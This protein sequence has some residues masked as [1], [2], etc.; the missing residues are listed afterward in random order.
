MVRN[1]LAFTLRAI[2]VSLALPSLVMAEEPRPPAADRPLPAA[3]EARARA[4]ILHEALHATLQIVHHTYFSED[5]GM[6][7]P[8]ATLREVFREMSQRQKVELRWLAVN[9]QAM[10]VD[11]QPRD[12]FE[13]D[14]A[15]AIAAGQDS[16]ELAENGTYRRAGLITLGSE[17]LKC[18]LPNRTSNKSRAAALVIAMPMKRG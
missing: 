12:D 16:Y 13:K 4:E 14:A 8:A 5:D 9:A 3:V 15:K 7:I 2:A 11:H 1:I 10:N 18:H 17:C 6:P